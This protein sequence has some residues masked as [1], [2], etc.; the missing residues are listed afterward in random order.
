[1]FKKSMNIHNYKTR[2]ST[3]GN[4]NVNFCHT[5]LRSMSISFVGV[6]LWNQLSVKL[7]DAV[8]VSQFRSKVKKVLYL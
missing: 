4:F 6:K 7:R 3:R 1:M 5:K 8:S 2:S